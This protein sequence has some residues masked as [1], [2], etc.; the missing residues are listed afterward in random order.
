MNEQEALRSFTTLG[1]VILGFLLS[2]ISEW[3]KSKRK[4][5]KKRLAIRSLIELETKNNIS[6]I[7]EFWQSILASKEKWNDEGGA[8]LY[9]QLA[10]QASR[11]P[12]PQLTTD[13]WKANLGEMPTVYSQVE[14]EKLW[15][16]QRNIE[17]LLSLHY[18]FCEAR[19]EKMETSR[20]YKG[21]NKS[22][23]G[24]IFSQ[25]GFTDSVLEL[26]KE[27]KSLSETILLF[28]FNETKS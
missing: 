20:F 1:A 11:K 5:D 25:L 21:L 15:K 7:S 8:F 14:L 9:V 13:A 18:F 28:N 23:V 12:F 3:V 22:S 4:S 27:F 26:A 16:L 6:Y 19:E 2:Q 10:E 24:M 17:R